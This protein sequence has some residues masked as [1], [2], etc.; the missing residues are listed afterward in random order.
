M[1]TQ[2]FDVC[3]SGSG[4]VAMT[5]ALALSADGWRVAWARDPASP[6]PGSAGD[7]RTYALNARAIGLLSRL[8]VWPALQAWSAPVQDMVVQ[9][10][11]GGALSFSAWQQCVSELAWI[12]D[13][14]ALERLLGE[15][16]RFA[17]RVEV[18]APVQ[19]ATPPVPARLLAVCEGKH[20]GTRQALGVELQRRDYGHWGV[21][22]RVRA[23]QPHQG[24][25][26]QWFRSPDILALLPFNDPE[27]GA[28]YGVVWSVPQ[29][30]ARALQALAPDDFAK[31]LQ[32]AICESDP[33]GAACV[34]ELSV[35][36]EVAAWPLALS[37][38]ERWSG[39]GWVL[40]GDAAHTV[41]PLS[42]QGLNL[43]LADVDTLVS[44]LHEARA[45]SPW[46]QAGDERTLRRYVRRR[47]LPT[48][49]MGELTDGLLNLFADPR[50][51][52]QDL[53]NAGLSLVQRLGPV[54]QWLVGRAIDA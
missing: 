38:A 54:K 21:A 33:A 40:L 52:V 9:G 49:A 45:E 43:G 42:G 50:S 13:A 28:S 12:V 23:S 14:G 5:L 46:R 44:V 51:P 24:V 39:P 18:V 8:R 17:P 37:R 53:R 20:S 15:A 25:A 2:D 34:G 16:L 35:G 27:P 29:A 41:H 31:T 6:V 32:E 22:T 4:A 36:A 11:R 7:V 3:V 48:R 47:S 30:R 10:D 26:R 19:G 1:S